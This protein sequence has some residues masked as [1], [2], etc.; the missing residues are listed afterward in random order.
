MIGEYF[1]EPLQGQGH[2]LC[3]GGLAEGPGKED[4]RTRI[5]GFYDALRDF[6]KISKV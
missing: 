3:I 5:K 2:V 1:A 6:P 4:G